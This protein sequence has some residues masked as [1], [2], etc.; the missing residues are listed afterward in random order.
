MKY[1][2]DCHSILVAVGMPIKFPYKNRQKSSRFRGA[3]VPVV[4]CLDEN[5]RLQ[6]CGDDGKVLTGLKKEFAK[7]KF[8]DVVYRVQAM[9][10][11]MESTV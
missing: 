4:C 7:R 8:G 2:G 10:P 1:D 6:F 5:G 11:P 3:E 9:L